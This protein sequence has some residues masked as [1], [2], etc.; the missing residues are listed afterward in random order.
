MTVRELQ[1]ILDRWAPKELAWERDNVGLQVGSPEQPVKRI[2]VALDCTDA[3]IG[4][5]LRLKATL[6]ITHHP[7]V[8]HPLKSVTENDPAGR[9]VLRLARHGVAL[10]SAHT[11]LDFARSGVSIALAERIGLKHTKILVASRGTQRKVVVFV[12]RDHADRVMS[13]MARSGAGHIG[14]YDLCSFRTEG[15]GTF[16]GSAA[17]KPSIGQTGR[18]EHVGEVRLEMIVPSWNLDAV[19]SAMRTVH[20]YE[21]PAYDVYEL[22]NPSLDTGAGAI[23]EL[24]PSRTLSSFLRHTAKVLRSG[25]LRYTGDPRRRVRRV[26]VC[27][28]GGTELIRAAAQQRADAFVT[29]DLGYHAF[30]RADG[31]LA[32]IDAG[33]FETEAPIVG[34]IV[35]FLQTRL[36][37]LRARV[38]VY[39]SQQ[40]LNP[41]RYYVT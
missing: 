15:T 21:E 40:S 24:V 23:G 9:L 26:A 13:A 1:E 37:D 28:G 18:L 27:G 41:V 8:Y 31:A 33:H 2:L 19:I 30:Q 6:I 7:L 22:S 39:A 4:E 17:A 35:T 16:R 3:V 29:A 36:A 12:P 25:A 38:H 10:F 34:K 20:P 11:N 5:A 32:L 14:E